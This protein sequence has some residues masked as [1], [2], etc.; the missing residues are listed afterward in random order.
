MLL[1]TVCIMLCGPAGRAIAQEPTDAS[2][3]GPRLCLV[4][5]GGGARGL[6][7]IGVLRELEA[8]HVPVDC[9]A[10]TSFGA[11]VGG[12]YAAGYSPAEIEALSTSLDWT[13]LV[14]DQPDRRHLPY[15]RK[16]DDL[17]YLAK[18]EVG[19][20]GSGFKMPT[21]FVAGHRVGV[22]LRI[23]GLRAA[24]I[25]DF[26]RLPLPF[27]A[28]ATD[29]RTGDAVVLK[30]GD[31]G[32]AMHASMAI[33]GLFAPVEIDGRLLVDGG[34]VAN[35]PVDATLT[36]AP[37]TVVAVD[38]GDPGD[39]E[40]G[41]DSI[42]TI[43]GATLSAHSRREVERSLTLADVAIQ[44]SV[45]DVGLLDFQKGPDLIE[46]GIAAVREHEETLAR[47]AVDDAAWARHVASIRRTTPDLT[48]ASLVFEGVHGVRSEEMAQMMRTRPGDVLEPGRL[49]HDLDRIWE[50]GD[51]ESVDFSVTPDPAAAAADTLQGDPA[52]TA[53]RVD[54]VVRARGKSWGPNYLRAGL[55]LASDLEG[56]S[57]F[58]ALG[59]FTMTRL[60]PL[61]AE[62][63]ARVSGG[64][65]NS[66]GAELYQPLRR[67]V[68]GPFVATGLSLGLAKLQVPVEGA[69]AAA[70]TVPE[71]TIQYRF[72]RTRGN[73]D[74]GL[75]LGR[76]G[77]LRAGVIYDRNRG[78]A[79]DDLR[80]DAP[81]FDRTDAGVHVALIVDQLDRV[82]FPR[83]GLLLATEIYRNVEGLGADDDHERLDLQLVAAASR[84]RHALFSI[85][86]GASALGGT[87]PP[88][89]RLYLGGLFS[90]SGLSP[91]ALSGSYGGSAALV[92]TYRLGQAPRFADGIYV[93]ASVEAGN[94]WETAAE[95]DLGDLR[96]SYAVVLGIDTLLG[97]VY[98]AHGWTSGG[99][100][101]FY[102]YVGRTF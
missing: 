67:G 5:S 97:P 53:S 82:N 78:R 91:G 69:G 31:L 93:G 14:R 60:N 22:E 88:S 17:T 44:P 23:L 89:S 52:V 6:A 4:L 94:A 10:G 96:H 50:L 12:L 15:R 7:H 77:E 73:A 27:R 25:D 83:R 79:T 8:M 99:K 35:L 43:L 63:K 28:V 42:A 56:S 74:L 33:P 62:L 9:V 29:A 95:V 70:P 39:E 64:D 71:D 54:V 55:A 19:V 61:G 98:V 26:D 48:V 45:A 66:F 101:S 38:L 76:Y 85:V 87:L 16:I 72:L 37:D 30:G 47:Y 18:I 21:G 11:I 68:V 13:A 46:R 81:R 36:M 100:D 1:S 24:G 20:A 49:A 75:A 32:A 34:I 59:A 3:P 80:D 51:I 90:L 57:S 102:L 84:G 58:N 86:R 2:T 41:A 65:T 40:T 92:Y